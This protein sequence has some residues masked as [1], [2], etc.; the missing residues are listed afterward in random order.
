MFSDSIVIS[1]KM[2]KL[3][4]F[5]DFIEFIAQMQFELMKAGIL[6]RGGIDI[7]KLY[8]DDSFIFGEALI[9]AYLLES[10]SAIFPRIVVSQ[11]AITRIKHEEDERFQNEYR[12]SLFQNGE[13]Y[14]LLPPDL[15]RYF[16][17]D[18]SFYIAFE[19]ECY[20]DFFK[21]GFT[22]LKASSP[23]YFDMGIK[24]VDDF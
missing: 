8:H 9:S 18:E 10:S 1:Q 15:D 11:K 17:Q 7:V 16:F 19:D 3:S 6:I 5:S 4:S 23:E 14:Y 2:D 24:L 20:I 21:L 13:R 22:M 12:H